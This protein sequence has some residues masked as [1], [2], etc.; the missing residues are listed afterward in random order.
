M[1]VN[2]EV[3]VNVRVKLNRAG[4]V[5]MALVDL[6]VP[7]GFSVLAEDLSR[8]VEQ[9]LIARYE[10]TG[11]RSLSISRTFGSRSRCSS[12]I[13]CRHVSRCGHRRL[14]PVHMTITTLRSPLSV[15]RS[16]W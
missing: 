3:T 5:K 12:A 8:L 6:G 13:A 16:M 9:K 1:A 15:R 2:D 4:V 14:L 7:P 11:A 10:L